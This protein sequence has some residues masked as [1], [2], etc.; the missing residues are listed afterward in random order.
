[1]PK[2]NVIPRI[3]TGAGILLVAAGVFDTPVELFVVFGL[4]VV[5][6]LL[7]VIFYQTNR[8]RIALLWILEHVKTTDEPVEESDAPESV[9][10][11]VRRGGGKGNG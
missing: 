7:D 5:A 8:N 11:L 3:F 9:K 4:L 10:K 2:I 6:F 1:M